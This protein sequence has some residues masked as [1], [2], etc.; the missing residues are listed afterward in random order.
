MRRTS[1]IFVSRLDGKKAEKLI[2][3]LVDLTDRGSEGLK[4][5]KKIL[6]LF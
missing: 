6:K 5:G 4:L 2:E 1:A 3:S